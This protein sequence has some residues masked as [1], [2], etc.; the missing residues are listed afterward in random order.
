MFDI[1]L[2]DH[3]V[4]RL[5]GRFDATQENH[6]EA[7]FAKVTGDLTVDM[8]KLDYVA[9]AGLSVLLRAYKRLAATG[10]VVRLVHV[11]PRVLIVLR[12]AGFDTFLKVE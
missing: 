11:P 10:N 4:V 9:S 6:A 3:G 5:S 1:E 8:A 2:D 12:T 7:V